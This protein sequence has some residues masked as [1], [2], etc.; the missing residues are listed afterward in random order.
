MR[1]YNFYDSKFVHAL[2]G[3]NLNNLL[4]LR[5]FS[6]SSSDFSF[7][8]VQKTCHKTLKQY[9]KLIALIDK[10]IMTFFPVD[11]KGEGS[12]TTIRT[13]NNT[14]IGGEYFLRYENNVLVM[15]WYDKKYLFNQTELG[16]NLLRNDGTD[17]V[18]YSFTR[19][20]K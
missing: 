18:A 20:V 10:V 1:I 12:M 7:I 14:S 9:T 16:F 3:I 2:V 17:T 4:A 19:P 13:N 11:D 15:G 8:M 5:I 6:S